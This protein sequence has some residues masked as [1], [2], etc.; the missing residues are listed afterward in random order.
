MQGLASLPGPRPAGRYPPPFPTGLPRAARGRGNGDDVDSLLDLLDARAD[1]FSVASIERS[2]RVYVSELRCWMAFCSML[3]VPCLPATEL[4]ALR[5][6]AAFRNGRSACKYIAALKWFHDWR[7]TPIDAWCTRALKQR[8]RGLVK[9][10][11]P[12]RQ[13]RPLRWPDV[14][15]L[16][17]EAQLQGKQD[18]ALLCTLSSAFL[19]RVPSEALGL[20]FDRPLQH[21]ALSIQTEGGRPVLVLSLRRR[22]NMPQGSI[23]RRACCCVSD[24]LMCAPHALQAW[25]RNKRRA[26]SG[27]LF[28]YP[29][30]SFRRDLR[31]AIGALGIPEPEAYGTHSFRRG[32]AHELA[33]ARSP[34]ADILAAGQW[35]S[36]AFL[37]YICKADVEEAAVLDI[38][39]EGSGSEAEGPSPPA[40]R[41]A[42]GQAAPQR[43]IRSFFS[44]GSQ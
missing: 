17:R 22:K 36:T 26:E 12:L 25:L 3:E 37:H 13:S 28:A 29:A 23:L 42:P 6:L 34:L 2:V 21:S 14:R 4:T 44:P 5:F 31:A 11:A 40:K 1:A 10:T 41:T 24:P 19:L 35:R 39:M 27:R 7:R 16:V 33:A 43:S 32:T 20:C 38:I 9:V 18:F 8:L 30:S 15:R